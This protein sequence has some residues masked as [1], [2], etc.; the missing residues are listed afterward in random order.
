[1]INGNDLRVG[2]IFNREL[3]TSRGMEYDHEFVLTEEWMG[4]LFSADLSI[5]L[6]DLFPIKLTSEWLEKMGFKESIYTDGK[7]YMQLD[8]TNYNRGP[9][10]HN[11]YNWR[12]FRFRQFEGNWYF[13]LHKENIGHSPSIQII[14]NH[15]HQLQNL[16]KELTQKELEITL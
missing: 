5:A 14:C 7:Q 16:Y 11:I 3:K 15:V 4:K 1:M 9:Y 8:E 10:D 13:E 6:D 12:C 2:N